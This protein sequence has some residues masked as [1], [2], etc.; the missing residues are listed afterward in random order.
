MSMLYVGSESIIGWQCYA[1]TSYGARI[2][3]PVQFLFYMGC[4]SD[5]T[6]E[7]RSVSILIVE[8]ESCF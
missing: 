7:S 6:H 1:L 8:T 3:V 2:I 5:V 4:A